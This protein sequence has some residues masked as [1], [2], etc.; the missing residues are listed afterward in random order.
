MRIAVTGRSGQ[1]VRALIERAG[2][3]HAVIALGRPDMDLIDLPGIAPALERARPDL[4]VSAAA[5]TGVDRAESQSDLAFA[6]NGA[7]AGEVARAA[8]GLNVPLI[9]LS[10]DYVFDGT[11]DRPYVEGDATGPQ[12]VYGRSKLVGEHAAEAAHPGAVILRTAWVYSPFGTNFVKTMLQ[13]ATTRDEVAVVADQIGNPTSAFDIADAVFAVAR[14]LNEEPARRMPGVFH[15]AGSGDA[16]WADLAEAVFAA[17]AAAGGP[18]A[19]VRRIRTADY[20]TPAVRPVN[21]RL[22]CD[23]LAR[24]YGVCLPDWRRSVA[25]VVSRLVCERENA[26]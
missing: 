8:Y 16:S 26:T 25:Q 22:N 18:F 5:Y 9:H 12:G 11:R 15:M 24:V 20:P 3:D 13:L 7:G 23:T 17:S 2:L 4:V 21:S 6:V 10:S 1:V 14:V 19:R